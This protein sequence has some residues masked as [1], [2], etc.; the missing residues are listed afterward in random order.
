M[1]PELLVA[2]IVGILG[3][4]GTITA[5]FITRGSM[6]MA[7]S[8]LLTVAI[9]G[10]LIPIIALLIARSRKTRRPL[11]WRRIGAAFAA[12]VVLTA[13]LLVIKSLRTPAP[14]SLPTADQITADVQRH[15]GSAS[16]VAV[17]TVG[18]FECGDASKI[19]GLDQDFGWKSVFDKSEVGICRQ[20]MHVS[21]P[22]PNNVFTESMYWAGYKRQGQRWQ[23]PE[24]KL[25]EA[26]PSE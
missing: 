9:L 15:F 6:A 8:I 5:A 13:V 25:I 11:E 19:A 16:E 3:Y 26:K 18:P 17:Q 10:L 1:T 4:L 22:Q 23:G 7:S 21:L 2:L 24:L 12:L 14:A 20:K